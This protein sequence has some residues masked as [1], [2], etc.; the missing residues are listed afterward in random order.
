MLNH[1]HNDKFQ[2]LP[3]EKEC[4]DDNSNLMKMA[5]RYQNG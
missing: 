1:F 5:E 3:N 2:V 4:A